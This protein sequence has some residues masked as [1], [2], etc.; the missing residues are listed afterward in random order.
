MLMFAKV[1]NEE[2][3]EVQVGFGDNKEYFESLGMSLQEVEQ[4]E[5][6]NYIITDILMYPQEITGATV[7]S[8][9]ENESGSYIPLKL[10]KVK[11]I[12]NVDNSFES[13][14]YKAVIVYRVQKLL[15]MFNI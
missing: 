6:G 2:T 12:K 7:T 14:F 1:I 3:K 9:D 15:L 4:T 10:Q 5:D 8:N 11:F 13:I